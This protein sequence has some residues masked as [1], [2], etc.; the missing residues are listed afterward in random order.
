MALMRVAVVEPIGQGGMIHYSFTLCR[1]L[2]RQGAEVTLFTSKHYE[3]SELPHEFTLDTG[4]QLWDARPEHSPGRMLQH[5]RRAV[6]G[7]RYMWEVGR[8][9]R[10]VRRYAPDAILMGEIRFGVDRAFIRSLRRPGVVLADIVHDVRPFDTRRSSSEVLRGDDGGHHDIYEQFDVLFVHGNLNRKTLLEISSID[11]SKVVSIPIALDATKR[12]TPELS[13]AEELAEQYGISPHRPV[14][15]FFG[16]LSKYKGIEDLLEI[17]P[18]VRDATGA[19]LLIGGF[20]AKDI[21]IEGL[22]NMADARGLSDDITWSLGYVPNGLVA[23]M[24][25][26]ADLVVLPYRA[27]SDSAVLKVAMMYGRPVVATRV[28]GLPDVIEDGVTGVLV[29]PESPTDLTDALVTL[30]S[31]PHTREMMGEAAAAAAE[32]DYGDEA[33]ARRVLAALEAAAT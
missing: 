5:L 6:R 31:D 22:R 21:D 1:A 9:T 15:L 23:P 27:I 18:D 3:L 26:L 32:R 24:M 2:Q 33:V 28:G 13:T 10:R 25:R 16:T 29:E 20:P 30:L 19:Q 12:L 7:V 11:E 8:L 4:L 17:F 14:V